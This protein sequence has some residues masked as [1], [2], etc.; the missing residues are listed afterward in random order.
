MDI[1]GFTEILT[2][3]AM[4]LG[5][6]QG[7]ELYKRRRILNGNSDDRRRN[8]GSNGG[9]SSSDKEFIRS[10]FDNLGMQITNGRMQQTRDLE[11]AIRAE[12]SATRVAVRDEKR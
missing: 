9:L 3:V 11:A 1:M 4:V 12:G 2:A 8:P 6:Q 10:C 7:F 5:G